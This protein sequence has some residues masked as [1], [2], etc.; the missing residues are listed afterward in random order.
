MSD[1]YDRQK[2]KTL[3]E[4]VIDKGKRERLRKY[5]EGKIRGN[6]I[7]HGPYG[8]GKTAAAEIIA[9][10]RS[11][12]EAQ[13]LDGARVTDAD[14]DKIDGWL[15]WSRAKHN[16]HPMVVINEVDKLSPKLQQR[17][18]AMIEEDREVKPDFV[19]TTN[20]RHLVDGAL[21]SRSR[22]IEF[23]NPIPAEWVNRAQQILEAEGVHVADEFVGALLDNAGD[24]IR[25]ILQTLEE[26]CAD[27]NQHK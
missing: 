27:Y 14:F 8:T 21:R 25:D 16:E 6:V 5:A 19:M 1:F 22:E 11:P 9:N 18:R 7:L 3:D 2:P 17:L 12:G 13:V 10:I 20:N 26:L 15:G 23:P 4:I 24:D